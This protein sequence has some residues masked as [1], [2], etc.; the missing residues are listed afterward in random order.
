MVTTKLNETVIPVDNS[1]LMILQ[2][3]KTRSAKSCGAEQIFFPILIT[4]WTFAVL[5]ELLIMIY[6]ARGKR[7]FIKIFPS[8]GKEY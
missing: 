6:D 8:T 4:H 3:M 5:P 1:I 7:N 2:L